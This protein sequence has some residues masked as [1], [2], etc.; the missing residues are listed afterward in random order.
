[1]FVGHHAVGFASKRLVPGVSL[2]WLVAA[3]LFLD[4]VWP[5]LVL[6]GVERVRIDPGNT[7]VTPLAFDH[8]PWSHSLAMTAAW[9]LLFAGTVFLATRN[10]AA[11]VVAGLGVVS[12][13]VLD[14]LSHG[15]D[16]PV[17]LSGPM[18]G[19]GL[20]RS[21]PATAAVEGV[22]FLAALVLY[23]RS[24]RPVDRVGRWAFVG[25]VVLVTGIWAAALTGTPPPSVAAVAGA[26]MAAWLF[27]FWAAWLDRH[28]AP[29][30]GKA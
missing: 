21:V 10:R 22:L 4:L 29:R 11:S 14:A 27:P 30:A 23:A 1:M 16:V 24:T 5:V 7:A 28:R 12:H 6:S 18:V 8:Y 26:G 13:W 9:G 17:G 19:L 2:G 15:P 20:W 3:P 25:Y